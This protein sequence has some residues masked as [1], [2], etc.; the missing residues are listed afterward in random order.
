MLVCVL[1]CVCVRS[2]PVIEL[3][4]RVKNGSL[5][6]GEAARD[7]SAGNETTTSIKKKKQKQK[8]LDE[9]QIVAGK[10]PLL[11]LPLFRRFIAKEQKII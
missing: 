1:V 11:E 8:T 10:L 7:G 3:L 6:L 5:L 9:K 4:E 2:G